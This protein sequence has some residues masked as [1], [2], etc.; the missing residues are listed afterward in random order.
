[1]PVHQ[2]E[3]IKASS[4]WSQE[5]LVKLIPWCYILE[6]LETWHNPKATLTKSSCWFNL[7][8][9]HLS[10]MR[11]DKKRTFG[12]VPYLQTFI[13]CHIILCDKFTMPLY[14]K[15][16]AWRGYKFIH[17]LC[18]G[19]EVAD[20]TFVATHIR[21]QPYPSHIIPRLATVGTENWGENSPLHPPIGQSRKTKFIAPALYTLCS[22]YQGFRPSQPIISVSEL[23]YVRNQLHVPCV[24]FC[25]NWF[26]M[27]TNIVAP[28]SKCNICCCK[29]EQHLKVQWW[30][31]L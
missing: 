10:T 19:T 30:P 6:Y 8:A 1:M 12:S 22:T 14:C 20:Y 4:S 5:N 13:W 27:A 3:L 26:C 28:E 11:I 17:L 15:G 2:T 7:L 25:T 29:C 24:E 21:K 9:I 18:Y 16:E 31:A 23:Q